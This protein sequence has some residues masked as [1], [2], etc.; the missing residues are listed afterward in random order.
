MRNSGGYLN[1]PYLAKVNQVCNHAGRAVFA[2]G[3]PNSPA[4]LGTWVRTNKRIVASTSAS[5]AAIKSPKKWRGFKAATVRDHKAIASY[6]AAWAAYLGTS[7]SASRVISGVSKFSGREA[8]FARIA[9]RYNHRMDE[10]HVLACGSN[11]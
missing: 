8:G 10:H 3:R 9:K 2:V 1:D 5:F 4:K 6:Y 7:P 11:A